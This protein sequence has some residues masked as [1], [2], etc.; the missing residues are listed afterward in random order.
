MRKPII[1]GN[2]KMYKT[3]EE[4]IGLANGIKR[5]LFKIENVEIVLCPPFTSLSDVKDVILESNI[6]LGAQNMYWEEEGAF[7]GEISPKMLKSRNQFCE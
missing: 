6:A 2:W 5:G 1:A 3:P 4:S 7:T